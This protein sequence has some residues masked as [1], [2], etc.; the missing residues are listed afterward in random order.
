MSL[1]CGWKD[2]P[3]RRRRRGQDGHHSGTHPQ[4]R[5]EHGGVSVFAGVGERTREGNDLWLRNAGIQI[6][7]PHSWEI[8]KVVLVF[9]QMKEPPG[10]RLRVGLTGLTLAEYFRDEEGR[11]CCSSSIIF[12][13][14]RRPARKYRRCWA[15]CLRRS[16]ISRTWG[17]KW[18]TC[19]S[20]LLQPSAGR[21]H[22]S[23]DLRSGRR[24][25]GSSSGDYVCAL[26]RDDAAF[27]RI[28][29]LGI[30]PAVDPLESTSRILDPRVVGEEHYDVAQ[31]VKRNFAAL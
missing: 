27:A 10:A 20:A 28:A 7:D 29:E 15:V 30:Y 2:W 21:L 19:R 3:V 8:S 18:A 25:D 17:P 22:R 6:V 12:S 24:L 11:T 13:G 23:G 9:G 1:T 16:V 31:R 14:L 26:G 4:H 5:H